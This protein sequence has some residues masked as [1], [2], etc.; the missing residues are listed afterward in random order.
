[1]EELKALLHE[2]NGHSL[3]IRNRESIRTFDGR[4]IADLL[5]LLE[6][7]PQLLDGASIADK[8][9]GKAAAALMITGHAKEIHAKLISRPAL[10]LL[11]ATP[12]KVTYDVLTEYIVN[13]A[14]TGMCPM[15]TACKDSNTPAECIE[16]I[17]KLINNKQ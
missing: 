7:E 12:I 5:Y 16:E 9:V 4:G 6:K 1:M 3:A 10:T 14:N 2:G 17:K 11:S 13:R 15:E 8:V